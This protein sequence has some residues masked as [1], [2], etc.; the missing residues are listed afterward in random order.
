MN[1]FIEILQQYPELALFLVIALGFA[2]GKI[3]IGNFKVGS[4]LGTLFAGV[5]VGQFHIEVDPIVKVI[6]FDLFLFATGYK[7]GPQFFQG[8]KK[9]AGPQLILTIILSLVSLFSAYAIGRIMNFDVGTTAGMLA[10]AFS[11]STIIGTASESIQ[12]L[13]LPEAERNILLNNIAVAYAVT[14]LVGTISLV[15]FLSSLAPKLIKVDLK[16]ASKDLEKKLFGKS[17]DEEGIES[18]FEDWKLRAFKLTNEK[19]IGKSIGD[20]EQSV[21]GFRIFIHRFRRE[22]KVVES[23][24]N[25]ILKSGDVIALMARYRALFEKLND[26]GPEVMDQE[27]LD[28]PVA[29]RDV[30]ITSKKLAGKTLKE[31]GLKYGQGIKLHKLIRTGQEIPFTPETIV[32]RGDLLKVSGLLPDVER[33]AKLIGY[34][35]KTSAETDMIFVGLGILL[36][37]LVGLLAVTVGGVSITLTTSGGALVMGLIFGWLRSRTPKVGRIPDAALWIFDSVGL[38]VFIGIIGLSAGPSF[39][40]GISQT[41]PVLL[42]AGVIIA[43]LPHVV[44]LYVGHRLLKINPVILLGAQA[45]AGTTTPGLK[46]IQDTA[47]SKMPVLGYTVPY[48]LGSIL[49]TA[50]GPVIVGMMS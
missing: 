48:A 47:E 1:S 25:T 16:S 27:L 38:A 5:L 12:R 36:G 6:F 39:I 28:Y 15:W 18:A 35:D 49:L 8:L 33:A 43:L 29:Y 32:N 21:P 22:G 45:G 17:E 24:S 23:N 9:D 3:S 46:A 26:I 11:Q 2:F 14:Y 44:G 13:P 37:G 4:A 7:V 34:V 20:I 42:L 31:L 50:W 40:S 30:I 19:W 10:G 41:G